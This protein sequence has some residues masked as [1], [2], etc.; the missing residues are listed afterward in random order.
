MTPYN[1]FQQMQRCQETE[2]DELRDPG[3]G[4]TVTVSPTTL[5]VLKINTAGNRNLQAATQLPIGTRV[6][7]TSSIAGVTIDTAY[8]LDA[9]EAAEFIVVASTST[10][11][12]WQ[13]LGG[14]TPSAKFGIRSL[15]NLPDLANSH[16]LTAA[17]IFRGFLF[18][19]IAGQTF[20]FPTGANLAAAWPNLAVGDSMVVY[21]QNAA[22]NAAAMTL[23]GNT[24][25]SLFG[26]AP[27]NMTNTTNT[28]GYIRPYL[29]LCTGATT[30]AI[31]PLTQT[32]NPT[33]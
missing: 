18:T 25:T 29:I 26:V 28:S 22:G 10:V 14:K 33:I 17:E 27:T 23:A 8:T 13:V 30:F 6:L 16:T 19:T 11:N 20:T 15:T 3:S 7:V 12:E 5:G 9:G 31:Y 24:G 1:I 21:F 32:A 4:G 2:R